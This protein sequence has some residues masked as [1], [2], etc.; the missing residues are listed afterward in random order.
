[1][2]LFLK[3]LL[4]IIT[5]KISNAGV[6]TE[7]VNRYVTKETPIPVVMQN[8][9]NISFFLSYYQDNTPYEYFIDIGQ[10]I[11]LVAASIDQENIKNIH[12]QTKITDG[13]FT[14][15]LTYGILYNIAYS[16]GD[17]PSSGFIALRS[18]LE[19]DYYGWIEIDNISSDYSTFR[20]NK[21]AFS[22]EYISAGETSSVPEPSH[23]M[24][25]TIFALP[26][27]SFKFWGKFYGN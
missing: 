18:R 23:Y 6:I 27:S 13:L 3:C 7:T 19:K 24:L 2:K 1:M 26:F 22:D 17:F 11:D 9:G 12:A 4:L 16:S 25:F 14:N 8:F 21:W 5:T 20:I 10:D 15:Q